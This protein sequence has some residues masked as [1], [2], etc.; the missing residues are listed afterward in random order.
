MEKHG[1]MADRSGAGQFP[2]SRDWY[3]R[4]M[5]CD[6]ESCVCN[7]VGRC[8]VPSRMHIGKDHKCRGYQKK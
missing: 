5:K 6:V 1:L 3:Q 8:E 2:Y 7:H 4:D